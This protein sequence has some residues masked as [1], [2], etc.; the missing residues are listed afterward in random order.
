MAV[1]FDANFATAVARAA[2]SPVL[3]IA[4]IDMTAER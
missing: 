1:R 4:A 2:L 3:V